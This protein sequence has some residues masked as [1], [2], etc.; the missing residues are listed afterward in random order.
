MALITIDGSQVEV[1]EGQKVLEAALDAGIYIPHLCH[2]KDLSPLGSCRMCVVE[3]EGQEGVTPSCKLEA[4]EGMVIHTQTDLV[5]SR[6]MLA[7]ELLLAGHPEDCST[8]PAY[9]HCELQ[10][11]IQYIGPKT[12]RLKMRSKGFAVNEE[13]PLILHDMDR[14]ILCGRCVRACGDLRQVGVLQYQKRE[15]LEVYTG[16][17]ENK[18]LNDV[19]CRFCQA[20]VEVCPTGTLRDKIEMAHPEKRKEENV[21]PCKAGCP[22]HT[23]I[24]SY[25]RYTRQGKYDEATAVIREKL[26]MPRSLGYICNHACEAD[27]KRNALSEPMSI[28]EIKR[29]AV[30]HDSGKYWRGKGKQLADTGKKVVVVGGGP[31]GLTAAY[32]LR[33]QGHDVTVKEALPTAGGMLSYGIPAY[34]L[35]R[36]IVQEEID[37]FKD[38]GVKIET[39]IHVDDP[40]ALLNDYDAVVMTIGNHVGVRLPLEGNDLPGV[41]VNLTFLQQAAKGEETGMGKKVLVLGGGNVAFDCARTAKRLGAEEIHVACLEARDKMT[42]SDEEI[43]EAQEEGI[44]VHPAQT[45]ER[46]TGTD[47]ATGVDFMK[48]KAF[49]FDENRRAVIEKEEGSEHHI[50]CDTVI[51]A[52]GQ[53]TD[54]TEKQG[55]TLGRGRSIAVSDIE[56]DK[57]TNVEGIFAAGD[58]IYG[59]KSVVMAIESG[60]QVASQVDRFLGGDGDIE[61]QLA[62]VAELNPALGRKE[63]FGDERRKVPGLKEAAERMGNFDMYNMGLCD[64][65]ICGESSRCLQC[66]LRMEIAKPRIWS[67]FV[68]EVQ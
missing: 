52:T 29:Y 62:P 11:L 39:G 49:Y 33:K 50:E 4:K 23:N 46:I 10:T 41:L 16:V 17:V 45:F 22:A 34:R 30:E 38:Q 12:G 3:V 57:S 15:D 21:I 31:A 14:C 68:K 35:P 20:C 64:E 42:S 18:L 67:D 7:L 61:E 25:I 27:C 1:A 51:F 53:G 43:E 32:Y 40:K 63:R 37:V 65:D 5:K 19:G 59:T 24:P 56:R 47:Y 6:R 48:V 13:N 55:L 54:L 2:H 60:R 9:G 44:F 58:C 28:R 8:C 66:D 26:T 36:E